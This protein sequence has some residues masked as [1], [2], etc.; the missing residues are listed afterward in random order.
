MDN[1]E[2]KRAWESFVQ[3]GT[4]PNAVRRVVAASWERSHGYQIPF[5]RSE[6]PLAPEAEV[7]QRS[8]YRSIRSGSLR[9]GQPR[10]R[11]I[12]RQRGKTLTGQCCVRRAFET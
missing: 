4:A 11:A 1:R 5:E 9:C 7:V 6:A 8:D 12:D 10:D 2:I 3:K